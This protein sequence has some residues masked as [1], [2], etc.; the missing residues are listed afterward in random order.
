ML[1]D[2]DQG[3]PPTTALDR[4]SYIGNMEYNHSF[5]NTHGFRNPRE[6][7]QGGGQEWVQTTTIV[8]YQSPGASA[9]PLTRVPVHLTPASSDIGVSPVTAPTLR[10]TVIHVKNSMSNSTLFDLAWILLCTVSYMLN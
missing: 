5:R 6:I 3:Q 8:K 9:M 7:T 4:E 1:I 2:Q 10:S